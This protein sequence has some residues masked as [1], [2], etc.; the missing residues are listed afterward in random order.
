[1]FLMA[2]TQ[3]FPVLTESRG[4]RSLEVDAVTPDIWSATNRDET[5]GSTST[6]GSLVELNV[7]AGSR[8]MGK[9][10]STSVS[11]GA[12]APK[13]W[14]DAGVTKNGGE[15]EG[16]E[17]QSAVD[18]PEVC[19][20]SRVTTDQEGAGGTREPI[21]ATRPRVSSEAEGGSSQGGVDGPR[22]GEMIRGGRQLNVSPIP[23]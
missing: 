2:Q 10:V 5:D 3:I 13:H 19:G 16:K 8:D 6:D 15:A 7:V 14:D 9:A 22:W 11:G 20:R 18:G 12:R 1:M 17:E 23:P 4:V 21:G